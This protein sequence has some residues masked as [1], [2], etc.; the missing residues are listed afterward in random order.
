MQ[1]IPYA[2]IKR[3]VA[4]RPVAAAIVAA[5]AAMLL[6]SGY[7]ERKEGEILFMVE[8]LPTAVAAGDIAA[9]DDIGELQVVIEKI[10]RRFREPGAFTSIADAAGKIARVDIRRR[11]QITDLIAGGRGGGDAAA[12]IPAGSR[13]VS[14]EVDGSAD[15]MR[16]GDSVDV[17]ATFDLR[18]NGD[19]RRTTIA[20]L[21]NALVLAVGGRI[22]GEVRRAN[23]NAK[24]GGIFG[25]AMPPPRMNDR[26]NILLAVAPSDAQ[27][28]IF[29]KN[30]GTISIATRPRGDASTGAYGSAATVSTITGGFD[31]LATSR[32]E[33]R[34]YKGK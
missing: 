2:F 12:I 23:A 30:S 1:R 7:I 11:M 5:V 16:P 34:E 24:A 3:L 14:V 4:R 25:G 26:T 32:K 21:E 22:M 9:G 27:R 18:G 15:S 28:L 10:P 8:P 29:A 17:M 31:E 33:F 20:I 19:A 6:A 13:A